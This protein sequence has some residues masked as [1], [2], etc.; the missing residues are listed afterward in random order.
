MEK[1]VDNVD[2]IITRNLLYNP[3]IIRYNKLK[4]YSKTQVEGVCRKCGSD[5]MLINKNTGMTTCFNC[6]KNGY[7]ADTILKAYNIENKDIGRHLL[8]TKLNIEKAEVMREDYSSILELNKDFV[9]YSSMEVLE[10]KDYLMDRGITKEIADI[11]RLGYYDGN[12]TGDKAAIGIQSSGGYDFFSGRLILPSMNGNGDV[13]GL[14]GRTLNGDEVKY[15][16]NKATTAYTKREVLYG[17]YQAKDFIEEQDEVIIVEGNFDAIKMY[18]NGFR[19]VVAIG[20][21]AIN[22]STLITL[23]KYTRNIILCLD[24]DAAGANKTNGLELNPKLGMDIKR[25]YL[26]EGLD[27]EEFLDKHSSEAMSEVLYG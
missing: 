19:N 17:L 21:V 14:T 10:V 2:S 1:Y 16:N 9:S 7:F 8:L 3:D 11:Y 20:G 24:G 18:L 13:V 6:G 5:K 25:V 22:D 27:P 15:I 12:F 23:S 26:P 4:A